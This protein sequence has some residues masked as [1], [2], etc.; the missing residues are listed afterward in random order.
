MKVFFDFGGTLMNEKSDKLAHLMLMKQIEKRYGF[1]AENLLKGYEKSIEKNKSGEKWIRSLD[2]IQDW[3]LSVV[4]NGPTN[5]FLEEYFRMHKKYVRLNDGAVELLKFLKDRKIYI[6]L[7]SDADL[8]YIEFQIKLIR[9]FF[10]SITT[11]EEAGYSKPNKIIFERALEK[12]EHD[13]EMFYIGD[14]VERDVIGAKA[15]GFK[16]ILVFSNSDEADYCA[17]DL[18]ECMEILKTAGDQ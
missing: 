11:S 5:W 18:S 9:K 10:D 7:I 15:M 16:T 17:K 12:S 4:K 8:P 13:Y 1:S 3:F 2:I 6:G 14:S